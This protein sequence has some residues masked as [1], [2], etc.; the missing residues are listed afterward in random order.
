M[1]SFTGNKQILYQGKQWGWLVVVLSIYVYSFNAFIYSF[2][3]EGFWCI[4]TDVFD[5]QSAHIQSGTRPRF[6]DSYF[7]GCR[8]MSASS[9]HTSPLPASS[10]YTLVSTP[11]NLFSRLLLDQPRAR[12]VHRHLQTHWPQHRLNIQPT[13]PKIWKIQLPE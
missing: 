6:I 9:Y 11:S 12:F 1:G 5:L 13:R 2:G 3:H 10:K 8:E 4:I 7:H